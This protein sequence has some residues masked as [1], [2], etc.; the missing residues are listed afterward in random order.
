MRE[1]GIYQGQGSLGSPESLQ[2]VWVKRNAGRGQMRGCSG[3]V[4][5]ES[6][7]GLWVGTSAS[8]ARGQNLRDHEPLS[9]VPPWNGRVGLGRTWKRLHLDLAAATD[10]AAAQRRL[11]GVTNPVPTGDRADT[12][13]PAGGTPG[14]AVF[15]LS[16]RWQAWSWAELGLRLENLLDKDYRVH[17]SGVNGGGRSVTVDV[18]LARTGTVKGA[19]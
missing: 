19:D 16:G 3:E 4:R 2:P 8:Y 17:G 13:I 5:W 15:G 10:W 12:R 14:F 9:R 1:R 18:R 11:S 7:N 6:R